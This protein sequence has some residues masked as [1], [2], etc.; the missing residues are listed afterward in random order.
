MISK[1]TLLQT[2][3]ESDVKAEAEQV[4]AQLGITTAEAIRLL[5]SLIVERRGIP[6]PLVVR[7]KTET[8]PPAPPPVKVRRRRSTEEHPATGP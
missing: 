7:E 6:F 8:P 1:G 5:L 4:F 2:R 3:I